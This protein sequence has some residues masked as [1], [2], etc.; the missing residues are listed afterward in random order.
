MSTLKIVIL[1]RV[2]LLLLLLLLMY[3]DRHFP[4][5]YSNIAH[6]LYHC[7]THE[8]IDKF[9]Y[10][11]CILMNLCQIHSGLFFSRA[12]QIGHLN[13]YLYVL[14]PSVLL[15]MVLLCFLRSIHCRDNHC[16]QHLRCRITFLM[17]KFFLSSFE[18]CLKYSTAIEIFGVIFSVFRM[19]ICWLCVCDKYRIPNDI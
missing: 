11:C 7:F 8:E 19:K 17:C 3:F 16:Y 6:H 18:M 12:I 9:T 10:L 4:F 14:L 1:K 13:R 5:I 2:L 15:L